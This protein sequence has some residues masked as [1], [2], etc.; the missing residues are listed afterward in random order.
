MRKRVHIALAVVL[1]ILAGVITWQVLRLPE[2]D[3]IIDGRPLRLWVEN[4][5]YGSDEAER[6]LETAGTN[7]NPT[8]LHS[9][10]QSGEAERVLE[11]AGTNANPTL[12]RMLRQKD[13][14]L[15]RKVMELLQ[16]QHVVKVHYTPAE[17]RNRVAYFAFKRLGELSTGAEMAIPKLIEIYEMEIS[18]FSQQC[19][20]GSLGAFGPA[21]KSA[22]PALVRGL[23][24][25]NAFVRCTTLM[26][27]AHI[28][29]EPEL[30][31]PALTKALS[32]PHPEVRLY[33][34]MALVDVASSGLL[35]SGEG[36][37]AVPALVK[38]LNDSQPYVRHYATNALN[39][40]DPEA[41]ANAGVK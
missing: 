26:E 27:L 3:P 14:P 34:C 6:F 33:A 9:L 5:V 21:A 1:V 15:K 37:Q 23:A 30:V 22:I 24:D 4:Y 36:K 19:T 11:K 41:A 17:W 2:P 8:L 29:S 10:R 13:S 32:D 16:K 39:W 20:A 40:I 25:S 7:A 38:A 28:H 35:H 18:P 12:L 31:V